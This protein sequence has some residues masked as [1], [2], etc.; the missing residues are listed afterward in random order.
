[1]GVASRG[2]GGADEG[3]LP[4]L[5][6][7]LLQEGGELEAVEVNLLVLQGLLMLVL[8]GLQGLQWLLVLVLSPEVGGL[9]VEAGG[10]GGLV[11]VL[12]L[13]TSS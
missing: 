12:V 5:L 11:L 6:G 1:M 9:E 2:G 8:Q 13:V 10:G 3:L 4:G 7:G